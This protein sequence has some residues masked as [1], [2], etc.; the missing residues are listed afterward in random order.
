MSDALNLIEED[1]FI[2]QMAAGD[3]RRMK[4][5]TNELCLEQ[6]LINLQNWMS[7]LNLTGNQRCV[8]VYTTE[9]VPKL[10]IS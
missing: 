7:S 1:I 6:T 8:F 4:L 2:T 10:F 9:R 3:D 5:L